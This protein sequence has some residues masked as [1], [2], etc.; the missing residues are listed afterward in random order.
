MNSQGKFYLTP[1]I[2]IT[3]RQVKKSFEVDKNDTL[4][5]CHLH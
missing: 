2:P 4:K 3:E 1:L 5:K